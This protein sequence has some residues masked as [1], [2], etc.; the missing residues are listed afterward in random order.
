MMELSEYFEEFARRL[1]LDT[2]AGF[3]AN[4]AAEIAAAHSIGLELDQLQKFLARRTE[5]TSVA[6]ALKGNTLSVE[7]IERILSARRNGAIYPKEVL[8]AAFTE[9]EIHEKSML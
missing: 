6:V 2:G 7:K 9:D 1:N 4:V 8:A 5:I 3:P